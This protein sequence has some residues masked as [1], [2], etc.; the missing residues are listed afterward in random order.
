MATSWLLEGGEAK[1][2]KTSATVEVRQAQNKFILSDTLGHRLCIASKDMC[3]EVGAY[4]KCQCPNFVQPDATPGVMTWP[5]LLEHM[6]NLSE[7]GAGQLKDWHALGE[8]AV[9]THNQ[10]GLIM[11]LGGGGVGGS[12]LMACVS[13][14]RKVSDPL[15]FTKRAKMSSKPMRNISSKEITSTW[16]SRMKHS[17]FP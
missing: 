3:K 8:R 7:W 4:P 6:D 2:Q 11:W 1:G 15:Q 10:D 5:E 16:S 17:I 13:T 12:L 9:D 14:L